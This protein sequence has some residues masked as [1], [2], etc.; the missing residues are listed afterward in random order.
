MLI[1]GDEGHFSLITRAILVIKKARL[2]D[3][4]WLTIA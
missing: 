2:L 3:P 4:D 1:G